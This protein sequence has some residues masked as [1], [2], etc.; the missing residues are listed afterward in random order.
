VL[1]CFVSLQ[2]FGQRFKPKPKPKPVKDTASHDTTKN[3]KASNA[4][5]STI[6]YTAEDSIIMT[7]DSKKVF[8][9]GKATVKSD[10]MELKAAYIDIDLEENVIHAYGV[11]DTTDKIIGNPEFTQGKEKFKSKKMTYNYKTKRGIIYGVITEQGEGYLHSEVTKRQLDGSIDIQGGKYTTCDAENPH[12]YMAL[13]K[14]KVIPNDRVISGPMYFVL[15]DV[16]IP[17]GLPFAYIPSKVHRSSGILFPTYGESATQGFYLQNGGYYFAFSDY[18]DLALTGDIYSKG[19]WGL[20]ARSVYKYR[21]H[22]S[23]SFDY[24]ISNMVVSEPGLPDYSKNTAASLVWTHQQ[25]P[26][27]WPNTNFSASVNYQ[28]NGYSKY[29]STSYSSYLN[30]TKSSSINFSRTFPGMPFNFSANLTANQTTTTNMVDMTLPTLTFNMNRLYPFKRSKPIGDVRWYEKISVGFS[31][32]FRNTISIKDSLLFTSEAK[33]KF[34]YGYQ[35]NVPVSTS[36]MMLKYINVSPSFNFNG[37]IYPSYIRDTY[38]PNP[39]VQNSIINTGGRVVRDTLTGLNHVYDFSFGVPFSTKIY[40]MYY[41]MFFKDKILGIRHV[42]SPSVSLNYAPDFG[43]STWGY[44]KTLTYVKGKDTIKENY[45][46][47]QNGIYGAPGTGK[48]GSVSFSLDNTLSMK[49]KQPNDTSNVGK[50]ISLLDNFGLSTSYSLVADSL[51]WSTISWRGHTRFFNLVDLSFNGT[52]DEYSY[53]QSG[54][55]INRSL[56]DDKHQLLRMMNIGGSMSFSLNS[57]TL[58]KP[59]PKKR[60]LDTENLPYAYDKFDAPWTLSFNYNYTL[61]RNG[62]NMT[63][64]TFDSRIMQTVSINGNL[65]LTPKWTITFMTAYDLEQR[66]LSA[67]SFSI[68]RDLHCWTMNISVIPFGYLQSY[69]FQI[70]IKSSVL[71]DVKYKKQKSWLDSDK[72]F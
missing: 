4:V 44:Y 32:N 47:Y 52:F 58:L 3:G 71:S 2:S 35:Y 9:Y 49:I 55:R 66:R 59:Q 36:F 30:N 34:Q 42:M 11:K 20:N 24:K 31:S 7:I 50:K 17:I 46:V 22:Y 43:T 15:A 48:S 6:N 67:T 60:N 61:D 64:K 41:P 53:N 13:T 25:D 62:F 69:S 45:S 10:D 65:S 21:Y 18:A 28:T 12:Y 70:N 51:K 63:T 23:G 39:F 72:N 16:P 26:K 56:W 37:R 68:V 5:K 19:S 8:L 1:L 40:G 38:D 14:A 27:A 54:Q 57:K 29:N 33:K